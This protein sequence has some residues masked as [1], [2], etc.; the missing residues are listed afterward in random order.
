MVGDRISDKDRRAG[1]VTHL[2][3]HTSNQV[4]ELV[5]KWDDGTVGIRYCCHEDFSLLARKHK[6]L[7]D[8]VP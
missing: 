4:I 8:L 6:H 3:G 1:T 7:L 2:I 5:V